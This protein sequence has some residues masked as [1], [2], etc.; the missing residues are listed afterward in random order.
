MLLLLYTSPT[1]YLISETLGIFQ[2]GHLHTTRLLLFITK[3]V[4]SASDWSSS[5]RWFNPAFWL[6]DWLI[7]ADTGNNR[8]VNCFYCITNITLIEIE[9]G[10]THY[11][12]SVTQNRSNTW[13][14]NN[15]N[16]FF[17]KPS[18]QFSLKW[19]Q[20]MISSPR[21]RGY[22]WDSFLVELRL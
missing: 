22:F 16:Q 18:V 7:N 6:V 10:R 5:I 2:S 15:K 19:P 3:S 4:R 8:H 13:Q 20:M 9:R 11:K 21:T 1:W 12:P 14:L 17:M